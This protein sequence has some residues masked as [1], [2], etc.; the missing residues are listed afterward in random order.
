MMP[1]AG[2]V[3]IGAGQG[4]FQTAASLREHGYDEPI[5]IVG[6]EDFEALAA[7]FIEAMRLHRHWSRESSETQTGEQPLKNLAATT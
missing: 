1:S 3:I 5:I 6:D 2:T 7:E 4:G